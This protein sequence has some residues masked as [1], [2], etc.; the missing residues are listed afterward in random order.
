MTPQE[1][2]MLQDFL[3]QLTQAKGVAKDREADALISAAVAQQPDAAYLLV[4]RSLLQTQ[5][6]NNA[7]TQ[8]AQ[9]QS[10]RQAGGGRAGNSFLDSGGAWGRPNTDTPRAPQAPAAGATTGAT[11][12][13]TAKPG[14]FSGGAGGMLGAV[15][16]TAAGIAGGAFLFQGIENLMG[17]HGSGSGLLGHDATSGLADN[18][19]IN[20][21]YA[22][23]E[24]ATDDTPIDADTD[25]SA[26]NSGGD[27][28]MSA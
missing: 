19:T 26:D 17:H 4:Q 6:L 23:D 20:N 10:E 7:Q 2:Q 14:F 18:T 28:S 3:T 12:A 13:P 15:A 5:A 16:A 8:I 11:P 22:A 25:N 27:D 9:L 1:S 24:A 21:Y